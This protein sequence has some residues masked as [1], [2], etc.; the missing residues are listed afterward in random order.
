MAGKFE[1]SLQS[2]YIKKKLNI[3]CFPEGGLVFLLVGISAE[4]LVCT[5][6]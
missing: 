2:V 5:M 3:S 6:L 4:T 1:Q